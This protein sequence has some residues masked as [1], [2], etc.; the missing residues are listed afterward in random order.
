MRIRGVPAVLTAKASGASGDETSTGADVRSPGTSR[1]MPC[2]WFAPKSQSITSMIRALPSSA[3]AAAAH[4]CAAR[5]PPNA[6]GHARRENADDGGGEYEQDD[7]E[8]AP[9]TDP[10]GAIGCVH[11]LAV[12]SH[13]PAT[14]GVAGFL[15]LG[16]DHPHRRVLCL[17]RA[18][19]VA[20]PRS[21]SSG[22]SVK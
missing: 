13:I 16:P 2:R 19:A 7:V 5:S 12:R 3:T 20:A 4:S 14:V 1:K 22:S 15:P 10:G 11:D 21:V 6:R 17:A 8:P 18:H 9:P